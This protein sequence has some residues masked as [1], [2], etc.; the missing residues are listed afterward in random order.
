MACDLNY[1]IQS[2]TGDCLNTDSGAFRIKI[3]G[4]APDYTITWVN[5]NQG[6]IV[7]LGAGVTEYEVT[8]LSGGTYTF[9]ITDSCI[10]PSNQT[11]LAQVRISTGF[12]T[13]VS[14]MYGTFCNKNNGSITAS[15]QNDYGDYKWYLFFK[16][17]KKIY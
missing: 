9:N 17:I 2:L 13:S 7:V 12:C 15:T 8:G 4:D 10:D 14:S 6:D 5:P 1:S 3:N 11:I 16:L